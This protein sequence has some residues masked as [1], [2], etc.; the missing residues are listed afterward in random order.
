MHSK[1]SGRGSWRYSMLDDNSV[2][3]LSWMIRM[4][5]LQHI[6]SLSKCLKF[7]LLFKISTAS[8]TTALHRERRLETNP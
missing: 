1:M 8:R 3:V 5:F 7:T 2:E 4:S 6:V